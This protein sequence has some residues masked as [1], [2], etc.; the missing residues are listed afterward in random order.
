MASLLGM[1]GPAVAAAQAGPEEFRAGETVERVGCLKTPSEEYALY[2]PEGYTAE[3][4]WPVVF[5]MDPRGRALVPLELFRSAADRHGAILVSSYSTRSDE[6]RDTNVQAIKAMLPDVEVRFSIDTRRLYLAGFSGTARTA[7][8]LASWLEGHVA[9]IIGIGAGLPGDFEPPRGVPLVFYGGAGVLDFNYEEMRALDETLDKVNLRHRIRFFDGGHG[10][11]PPEFCDDA[12]GW[13]ELQA[14]RAGL[15]PRDEEFLRDWYTRGRV[16]AVA[17]EGA[18]RLDRAQ[19]RYRELAEDLEGLVDVAEVRKRGVELSR[20]REVKQAAA[21]Q[22]KLASRQRAFET[23]FWQ[24]LEQLRGSKGRTPARPEEVLDLASV[25]ERAEKAEEEDEREAAQRL[26]EI[27]FVYTSF[28]QPKEALQ[29]GDAAAAHALL[30]IAGAVKPGHPR[31]CYGQAQALA[32]LGRR[33]DA[34]ESLRCVVEA[35]FGDPDALGSDPYL[36]PLREEPAYKK[37][38]GELEGE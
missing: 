18:G 9:G 25:R 30:E 14:M 29:E 8:I 19:R 7:W 5:L 1:V 28:Y 3:R 22:D 31:V 35:G 4:R 16:E 34:V 15:L 6:P 21:R 23:K 38:L 10:W 36:E 27:V 20:S 33:E 11:A 12:L 26:I 2:L 24:V 37:L 13:M 32:Q 17:F